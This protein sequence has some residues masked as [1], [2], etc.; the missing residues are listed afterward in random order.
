MNKVAVIFDPYFKNYKQHI[1]KVVQKT[2]KFL[3]KNNLALDVY[4]VKDAE[5]KRL[6]LRFRDKNKVTNA[7][8]FVTARNFP[9]PDIKQPLRYLGEIYLAPSYIKVHKE[10]LE[11]LFIH[12]LLHLL[13][14]THS[15]PRDKITMEKA[16]RRLWKRLFPHKPF[17]V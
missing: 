14:Y 11:Y 16:E 12:G 6:N 2:L 7:L 10:S 9:H 17:I 8:S 5:I 4:L 3:K 15:R 1:R 13:G